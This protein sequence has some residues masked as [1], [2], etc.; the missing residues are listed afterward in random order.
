MKPTKIKVRPMKGNSQVVAF[1]DVTFDDVMTV[2]G[3]RLV[4]RK[5]GELFLGMPSRKGSDGK[6]YDI[7]RFE[8]K[9]GSVGS[10][11][12][13]RLLEVILQK[14]ESMKSDQAFDQSKDDNV[15]F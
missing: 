11:Y 10:K 12:K 8:G 1:V 14:V 7:V 4:K 2:T 3:I 15:P 5:D 9:A 6:Y 13:Q